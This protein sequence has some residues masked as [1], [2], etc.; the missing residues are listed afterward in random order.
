MKDEI[1]IARIIARLNVGGP[2]IQAISMTAAFRQRGYK[3]VLLAGS[4]PPGEGS[5]EYL[6]HAQN[7]EVVRVPAMSRQVSSLRDFLAF[8]QIVRILRRNKPDIVH[9]HTAKAG[10]LGRLA[11]MLLCVP[12]RVHT[13]HGHVFQGYFSP[14]LTRAF[15]VIERFLARYT[16][17]IVAVSPSQSRE[18]SEVY[19]VA[20]AGKI[21]TIP[22][23]FDLGPFLSANGAGTLRAAIKA[24]PSAVLVGWIG[25]LAPIK[26]PGLF[27]QSVKLFSEPARV[28]FV[29]VGDGEL[30]GRCKETIQQDR[31][32][33]F[34]DLLGWRRDLPEIY[35]DLDLVVSTSINEGTPIALI[36]AMAS[37]KAV[38]S[39]DVGGV[40]D[41]MCGTARSLG[42]M[43]VFEN[44]ILVRRDPQ[45][46]A[47]AIHYLILHP[48]ERRAMGEAGRAFAQER[49]SQSR[50]ADDLEKLYLSLARAKGLWPAEVELPIPESQDASAV[51]SNS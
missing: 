33:R 24:H 14:A 17:C 27:L 25:R 16:D 12:I 4:L 30:N 40:R 35:R 38:V 41:L 13:F 19:C 31:L 10:T 47:D 1:A 21:A 6:A 46:V 36:E 5:M 22:L 28:R 50:L 26:D 20:P 23:G 3:A 37:G 45:R 34:V 39:T 8:L 18:L 42:H 44:G 15:L 2:A 51:Q 7:V 43:D 11:A 9:T 49:F 32:G 48:E 29:M